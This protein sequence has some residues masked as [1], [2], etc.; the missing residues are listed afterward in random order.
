MRTPRILALAAAT[1]GAVLVAI[2]W[3]GLHGGFFFD[4]GASIL[5]AQ[6]VR[7]EH[8]SPG[9]IHQALVSGAAG[10]SGRPVAQL[11]FALNYYFNGFD[12]FFF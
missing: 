10:P 11:S 12:P 8:L 4:D 5:F 1:L 2:Y 9:S 3:P 7:L 6:G